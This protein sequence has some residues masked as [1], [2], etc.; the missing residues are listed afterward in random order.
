MEGSGLITLDAAAVRAGLDY[1]GCIGMVR[2]AMKTLSAGVT[3][4][5][6]RSIIDLGGGRLFG[7]MPGALAGDD[8]FGAKLVS[9]FPEPERPSIRRHRGLVVLFDPV[10][11]R[12]VCVADAEE[13]THIRTAAATAVATDALARRD[14]RNLLLIGTGSQTRTHLKALPLVRDFQHILI[15][16]RDTEKAAGLA[17]DAARQGLPVSAVTDLPSA[18][19]DAEV[20]CTLTGASQPVLL[21]EWLR[22]GVH[23]N[24]VGSSVPGPVEVDGELVRR[25]RYIVDSRANALVAAA[26]FLAARQAGLVDDQHIVAEIGE[27]LLGRVTGRRDDTDITAYKSLGHAVQDLAAAAHLYRRSLER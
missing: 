9:V 23:V 15:W 21:G 26:E 6:P 2:E 12:P 20:I 10:D 3:L 8:L 16:G 1:P 18:V 22:P 27:V 11:G 14:V 7:Q 13:I 4:Q 17:A 25:C 24:L 19:A 5:L